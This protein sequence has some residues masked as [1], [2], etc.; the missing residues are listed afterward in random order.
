[1]YIFEYYIFSGELSTINMAHS[2]IKSMFQ[3][4]SD[5]DYIH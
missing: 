1:M 3:S 4:D 5:K 2:K